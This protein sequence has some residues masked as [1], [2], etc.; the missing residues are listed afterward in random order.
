MAEEEMDARE[1]VKRKVEKILARH[2]K[3]KREHDP[4][5]S[6]LE[7]RWR[8]FRD[9]DLELV[10]YVGYEDEVP[11][12]YRTTVRYQGEEVFVDSP[13]RKVFISGDWEKE[14]SRLL[15]NK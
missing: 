3:T 9:E 7:H 14:L 6:N 2:G 12:A 15:D 11:V 8:T 1:S 10:D 5:F 4:M 13:G